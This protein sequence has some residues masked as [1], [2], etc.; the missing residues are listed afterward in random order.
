MTFCWRQARNSVVREMGWC[1]F[2]PSLLDFPVDREGNHWEIA[3]DEEAHY[4]LEALD[5]HPAPLEN[6][7][8]ALPDRR[9]GARFEALW[10]YFLDA[11]SFY[12]VLAAN[13]QVSS[14][15]RTLG[16]LD[17]LVEDF[18]RREVVHLELA[19]KFYLRAPWIHSPGLG[20]WIGSNPDDTLAAKMDH[21]AHHQLPLSALEET[22]ALLKIRGLP[23]PNRRAA[24]L[25]G[26]LFDT[27]V[28]GGLAPE[29]VNQK[30][31][32]GHWV[33]IGE[34]E[35]L[36]A[37]CPQGPWGIIDKQRW[38]DPAPA[39]GLDFPDL[40]RQATRYFRNHSD[41]IMVQCAFNTPDNSFEQKRFFV[42]SNE[43]PNP[44][45]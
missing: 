32:R 45:L 27:M 9:L 35:S 40:C 3:E 43:W 41:P 36:A 29:S 13:L 16:A 30:Y 42:V 23:L 39:L 31:L 17:F 44:R 10:K 26:Y 19:V 15:A 28:G 4:I 2:S 22:S 14:N 38:L 37:L 1:L 24:V 25:K 6:Y 12:Q 33:K 7:L 5:K 18:H 11:H 34:L 20:Q 21:L 8:L